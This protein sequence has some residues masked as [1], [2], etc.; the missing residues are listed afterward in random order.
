MDSCGHE[1]HEHDHHG[2]S[3]GSGG[4]DGHDHDGPDRGAEFSL[5]QYIDIPNVRCL[6][7]A[8]PN[9]C[10]HLFKSWDRRLDPSQPTLSDADEQLILIIP[11]TGNMKIKSI[12]LWSNNDRLQS[13]DR[14]QVFVNRDDIDFDSVESTTP[15]QEWELVE[16]APDGDVVEY[17]T[18]MAKFSGVRSLAIF[19]PSNFGRRDVTRLDY[20]GFKGEF[21]EFKKDPI[22]TVYELNANPADHPKSKAEE[23]GGNTIM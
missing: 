5:Y 8:E 7:E 2:H 9:Q 12:A 10:R 22:V 17:P 20:V 3:H 18:K 4:H 21:E 13:P 6:N 19:L 23:F 14:M 16:R 11:F 15:T 1:A